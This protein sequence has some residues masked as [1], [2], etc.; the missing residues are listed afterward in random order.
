MQFEYQAGLGV[1]DEPAL[2]FGLREYATRAQLKLAEW[3]NFPP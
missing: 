1:S 3:K 2:R